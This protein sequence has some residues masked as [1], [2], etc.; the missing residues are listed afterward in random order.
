[1]NESIRNAC[2]A[3]HSPQTSLRAPCSAPPDTQSGKTTPTITI[4]SSAETE[5]LQVKSAQ[6]CTET[7]SKAGTSVRG[8]QRGDNERFGG[9]NLS[10]NFSLTPSPYR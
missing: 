2:K 9:L 5:Q 6:S 7:Q 10:D 8:G 1:M 3:T 4:Q